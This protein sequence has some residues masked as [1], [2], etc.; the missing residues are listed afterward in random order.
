MAE[1]S[2]VLTAMSSQPPF[3]GWWNQQA[4]WASTL[5]KPHWCWW[6]PH[7]STRLLPA[8]FSEIVSRVVFNTFQMHFKCFQI[9]FFPH[10]RNLQYI[11]I[12]SSYTISAK[13]QKFWGQAIQH[14]AC[15]ESTLAIPGSRIKRGH[16]TG[17]LNLGP[18][19]CTCPFLLPLLISGLWH[20]LYLGW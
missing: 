15:S 7:A 13:V 1:L 19:H 17:G 14:T 9:I 10:R 18:R 16:I 2:A 20:T 12:L 11:S 8:H 3:R 6:H 5:Y 4:S